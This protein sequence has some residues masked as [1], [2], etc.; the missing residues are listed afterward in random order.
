MTRDPIWDALKAA[1]KARFDEARE[2]AMAK[3]ISSDDGN[4][5]KHT[6]HHWSR[7]L[8][9]ER[10]DYWPSRNKYMFRGRVMRGDVMTFIRKLCE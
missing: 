3:A 6:S 4:W 7:S 9:G 8:D 5:T 10:L 2:L 1:S